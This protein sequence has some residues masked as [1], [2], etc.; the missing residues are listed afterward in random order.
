MFNLINCLLFPYNL[1]T[2]LFRSDKE[3]SWVIANPVAVSNCID[4]IAVFVGIRQKKRVAQITLENA[5]DYQRGSNAR[6]GT[7]LW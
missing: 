4:V 2:S 5:G 7:R 6:Y 1:H 3:R